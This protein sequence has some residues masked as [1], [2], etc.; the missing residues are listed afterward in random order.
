M[1]T[2]GVRHSLLLGLIAMAT[3]QIAATEVHARSASYV[4]CYRVA[5]GPWTQEGGRDANAPA[6]LPT[7]VRLSDEALVT[8]SGHA[9]WFVLRP[10]PGV[11]EPAFEDARWY[12]RASDTVEVRW[13]TPPLSGVRA[14][15]V[16]ATDAGVVVLRG[17]ATY[18]SDDITAPTL[19][20]PITLTTDYCHGRP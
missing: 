9:P 1:P 3:L 15:L 16:R 4:A 8:P 10:A 11:P 14:T 13:E 2:I 6:G 5:V 20:A 12:V 17:T 7:G 18:W 19:R